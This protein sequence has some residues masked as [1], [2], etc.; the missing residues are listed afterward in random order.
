M[1][2]NATSITIYKKKSPIIFCERLKVFYMFLFIIITDRKMGGG[3]EGV[4]TW[5]GMKIWNGSL[6]THIAT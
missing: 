5:V 3:G 4:Y 1:C 6:S 2:L